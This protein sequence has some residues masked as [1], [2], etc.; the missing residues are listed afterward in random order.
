MT[1]RWCDNSRYICN[2]YLQRVMGIAPELRI[3]NLCQTA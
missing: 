3:L 1:S 2:G